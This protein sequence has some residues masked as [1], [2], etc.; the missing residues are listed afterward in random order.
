[1]KKC[2]RCQ[3]LKERAQFPR[4][5]HRS[6]GFGLVVLLC[7][8]ERMRELRAK[9]READAEARELERLAANERL[10][11]QSSVRKAKWD[12]AGVLAEGGRRRHRPAAFRGDAGPW[13]FDGMVDFGPENQPAATDPTPSGARLQRAAG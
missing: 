2:G 5:K 10:R 9:K 13:R 11:I 6:D 7:H 8:T 1:M 12:R 3:E 4:N